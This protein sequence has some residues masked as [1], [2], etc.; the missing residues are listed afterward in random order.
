VGKNVLDLF[1][2][3]GGLSLGFKM[4]GFN[5]SGGIDFDEN[6]IKTHKKNFPKCTDICGDIKSLEKDEIK[7]LFPSV[8][9]IIGGPPCQG[10]SM[11]NKWQTEE[12]KKEKNMLF[13]EYM[14]FVSILKP[15]I[16][17][18]ENVRQILTSNNE[19][20][21]KEITKI[22]KKLGYNIY[23]DVLDASE[24][25][26]PQK[27][28]R[29]FIIGIENKIKIGFNFK[30]IIKQEKVTVYDAISDLYKIEQSNILDKPSTRYQK[31]MQNTNDSKLYNHEIKYP[32]KKVQDRIKF[33]PQGGNWKNVPEKMWDT[34]R[35][36]RHSS[37]YRRLNENTVSITIDTGHMNYFHPI[38]NRVPTVRES[39]RLQ[40]FPDN[41]IFLGSKTSQFKQVGNAV[42]PFLAKA[43]A[44]EIMNI[45][46]EIN[47]ENN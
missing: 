2:G 33:V 47:N 17:V 37:A 3:A 15:K 28:I 46:K 31:I 8:D 44:T 13:Y 22:S 36:N 27:R 14:R 25:G 19:Y 18:I 10:F 32:I 35:T 41:F 11:A 20:A 42:P 7:Y 16:F 40:S 30:K 24:Y 12:E 21:K 34:K 26:V 45:I 43:V 6:A 4:A 1:C 9:V 5:I 38:Y 23:Y 39:A 29:T